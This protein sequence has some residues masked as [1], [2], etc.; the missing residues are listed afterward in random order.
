M[1]AQT[2]VPLSRLDHIRQSVQKIV[3]TPIG[4]RVMRRDYGSRIP[5]LID[6]PINDRVKLL[7]QA[8][9]AEAL[10]RWEK[11]IRPAR[12]QIAVTGASILLEITAALKEGPTVLFSYQV[13]GI[14]P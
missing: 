8:A 3:T 7:I 9:T 2:G 10:I 4:S 12:V 14:N 5:E 1:Q 13:S 11:R 6:A